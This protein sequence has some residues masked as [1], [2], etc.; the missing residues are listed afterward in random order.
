MKSDNSIS[1][2]REL[3]A[4]TLSEAAHYLNAP[5]STIRWWSVGRAHYQNLIEPA[6]VSGGTILL[7][8]FNLVELHLLDMI[9]RDHRVK[10]SQVRN[11]LDHLKQRLHTSHHPLISHDMQTNGV[12]LFVERLGTLINISRDG[13]IAIRDVLKD[14]LKRIERDDAGL[15]I[16]LYPYTR[17]TLRNAPKLVVIDSRLSGGRPV[18]AGTGLA[19][20]IIAER[21]KAGESIAE[22]VADYGRS[23]QEIEEAIRCE[24]KAAA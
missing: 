5:E 21:Y 18:I 20:E 2:P 22:L 24:L 7:S 9:R 16:K 1:D 15:P 11:A 23:E 8:F 6:S 14:A 19:T 17:S 10:M 13:Q 12:D 4:Y 3:P